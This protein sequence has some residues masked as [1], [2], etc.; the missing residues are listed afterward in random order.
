MLPGA[1]YMELSPDG[2]KFKS[3]FTVHLYGWNEIDRFFIGQV[4]MN[5]IIL[6]NFVDDSVHKG[7]TTKL[8]TSIAGADA[9]IPLTFKLASPELV[10]IL[11]DWKTRYSQET[12]P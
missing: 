9:G 2:I 10:S 3:L 5:E 1:S 11:N 4:A 12:Q 8:S 6:F 7:V